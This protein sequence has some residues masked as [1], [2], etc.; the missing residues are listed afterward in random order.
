MDGHSFK[1][2]MGRLVDTDR[3]LTGKKMKEYLH[4]PSFFTSQKSSSPA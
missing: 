2:Y 4:T 1:D 3:F